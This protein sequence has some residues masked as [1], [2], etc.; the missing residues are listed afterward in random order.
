MPFVAGPQESVEKLSIERVADQAI[1]ALKVV[2]LT[3]STNVDLADSTLTYE[4]AITAG[5]AT[6]TTTGAGQTINIQTYGVLDDPFF[7][8]P[9]NDLLFLGASGTITNV[10]PTTGHRVVLG[11]SLGVGS[12]FIEIQEPII[13]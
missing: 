2:R 9:L 10:A 12:I 11:K 13:L 6:S 5:V 1:S 3:S 7:T 8:F 4:D